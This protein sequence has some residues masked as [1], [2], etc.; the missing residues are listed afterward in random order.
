MAIKRGDL[1]PLTRDADAAAADILTAK[2]AYVK[3]AKITGTCAYDADTSD[4]NAVAADIAV[5]KTAYVNGSKITGTRGVDAYTMALLHFN[6]DNNSTSIIDDTGRSWTAGGGAKLS[7][8]KSVYGA[9][10]LLLDG[11]GDYIYTADS[12]DFFYG[13]S[14]FTIDFWI[15][16][17]SALGAFDTFVSQ[18]ADANNRWSLSCDGSGYFA[19]LYVKSGGADICAEY[20]AVSISTDTWTHLALVR[21][22]AN[23]LFFVNGILQSSTVAVDLGT[24]SSPNIAAPLTVGARNTGSID[25]DIAGY[26][27]EFRIS[28]GIAR[29]TA[30]FKPG[31]Q[32]GG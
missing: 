2:L 9:S 5:G 13:T 4:A 25:R 6:G 10:S 23:L 17:T 30:T 12:D 24:G 31:A 19:Y 16:P 21:N 1:V 32:Y 7:T 20:S 26:I 27:D 22:G 28:K 11:T 14:D 18:Y 15:Y 29:W 3:G 8:A